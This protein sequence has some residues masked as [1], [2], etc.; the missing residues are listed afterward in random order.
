MF[1][2]VS[3]TIHKQPEKKLALQ[4][5]FL[6]CHFAKEK[7]QGGIEWREVEVLDQSPLKKKKTKN[8]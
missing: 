5:M 1:E 4:K 3:I 6:C 7:L 8:K 2:K